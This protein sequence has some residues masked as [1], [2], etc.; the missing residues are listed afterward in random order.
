MNS[1]SHAPVMLE[2][3]L[4]QLRIKPSGCYVD[5]TF[6]RGGHTTGILQQLNS[7]G[8]VIA[9]DRDPQAIE[10]GREN[11]SDPR[12]S[13]CHAKFS[14]LEKIANDLNLNASID[15]ILVDLGVSSPQLDN[16]ERGFSFQHDGPLDMRMD[17]STGQSAADWLA[18]AKEQEIIECLRE[19]GEER[20]AKRVARFIVEDR[21]KEPIET[22]LQLANLVKRA[23]PRANRQR[24]HPATR[25]FQA[26][27]IVVN[28]ELEEISKLLEQGVRLLASGGR[29]V[30]IA[31]HSLEDR[32]VKRFF[33]DACRQQPSEQPV[34]KHQFQ[35]PFRKP[36]RPDEDEER[37]NARARSAKLRVIERTA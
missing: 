23:V 5:C 25:T 2:Q 9:L 8:R 18:R 7:D 26:L 12:L 17:Y 31:F 29:M 27:R 3:C 37:I 19:Y 30:V 22:T 24:I 14:E 32:I 15:G 16:A 33:R 10:F 1:L 11:L 34:G 36:L 35:L 6:G 13:L 20:H 28:Q 21:E 4:E